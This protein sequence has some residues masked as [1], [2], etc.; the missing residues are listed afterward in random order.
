MRIRMEMARKWLILVSGFSFLISVTIACFAQN[1]KTESVTIS[2]YYPAPYGV[3]KNPR[4]FPLDQEPDCSSDPESCRGMMY[5]NNTDKQLYLFNGTMW[6]PFGSGG[7]Y[8]GGLK[9]ESEHLVSPDWCD[10]KVY[11]F[12]G[13]DQVCEW[14]GWYKN[15]TFKTPFTSIPEVI[16]VRERSPD[17]NN[18]PCSDNETDGS[19]VYA[20][21]IKTTGFR[22]KASSGI[23]Y[24]SRCYQDKLCDGH[25]CGGKQGRIEVGWIAIGK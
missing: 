25:P 2:T 10:D 17:I 24:Y 20:E 14:E 5:F 11:T 8:S 1:S 7:G 19:A 21:N 15:I 9:I 18:M 16:V 6:K 12:W 23:T 4:L 22:I 13:K 3:Y